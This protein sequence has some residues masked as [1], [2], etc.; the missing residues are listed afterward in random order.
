MSNH[1]DDRSLQRRK[2]GAALELDHGGIVRTD[3]SRK[4]INLVFTGHEFADGAETI[5][6]ILRKHK[7]KA[8]FFFTGDFYR[9]PA[10]A[11]SIRQL[12]KDGHYLGA[13][14][15]RHLLYCSWENR[16]STLVSREEFLDDIKG[17]YDAMRHFG[18]KRDDAP[19]FLPAFEWYNDSISA[20]CREFGLT[21]VNF[22]PGTSSNAD[23]TTPDMATQYLSSD[24]IYRRIL[25][26]EQD[27]ADGLNG[28]ILLV[29]FGTE[30]KRT[31]KF[32]RKLDSLLTELRS[33]KYRFT[34]LH[35][36]IPGHS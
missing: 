19:F 27:H 2:P 6:R 17:N 35:E 5:A 28:F 30:P 11:S 32:Y 22:T 29:H 15:D 23:Y 25:L 14:S 31:D 34:L 7:I 24:E 12:K 9:N 36:T 3:R 8:S 33:R 4:E 1:G 18:I 21:L 26:Y 13:H 10:H 16:D 20:W